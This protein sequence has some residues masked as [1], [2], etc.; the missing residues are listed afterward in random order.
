MRKGNPQWWGLNYKIHSAKVQRGTA[1][2]CKGCEVIFLITWK[3]QQLETLPFD[4][5]EEKAIMLEKIYTFK[6]VH[7][8]YF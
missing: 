1:N 4:E 5:P 8:F 7:L 3:K 2:Q 6:A